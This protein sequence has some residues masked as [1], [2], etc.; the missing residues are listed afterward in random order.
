[1]SYQEKVKPSIITLVI[2]TFNHSGNKAA[3]QCLKY[4]LQIHNIDS[5]T[6]K[7]IMLDLKSYI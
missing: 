6:S 4:L 1:M 7:Q 5:I 2:D 3:K